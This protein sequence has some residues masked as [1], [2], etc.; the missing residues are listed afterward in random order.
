MDVGRLVAQLVFIINSYGN[1]K[2]RTATSFSLVIVFSWLCL[3]NYLRVFEN[4]RYLVDMI[5]KCT[6]DLGHFMVLFLI[7]IIAFTSAR[8]YREVIFSE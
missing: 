2:K 6:Q 4:Y 5:L 3:M 7:M 8:F 1:N